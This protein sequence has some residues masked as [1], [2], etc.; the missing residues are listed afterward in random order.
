MCCVRQPLLCCNRSLVQAGRSLYGCKLPPKDMASQG[1]SHRKVGPFSTG[2]HSEKKNHVKFV[3]LRMS[4]VS[5]LGLI[6]FSLGLRLRPLGEPT[7]LSFF[8]RPSSCI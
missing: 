8:S 5:A 6:N 7:T 1:R 2:P 4:D 3:P